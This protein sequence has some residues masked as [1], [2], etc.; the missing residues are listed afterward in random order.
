MKKVSEFSFSI[1]FVI[2]I[3]SIIILN[4]YIVVNMY[5]QKKLSENIFR[6]H[7]V[8]NSNSIDDQIIKLKI[9]EKVSNYIKNITNNCKNK[10]EL[11]NCIC[12]NIQ[13]ILNISNQELKNNNIT[14][15]TNIEIGN[16]KYAKKEDIEY[17]M[18]SGNY[19]SIK[20]NLGNANGK[21]IWSLLFPNQD[22]I[23][24]LNALESIL[25]G[26]SNIYDNNSSNSNSSNSDE[27]KKE[28]ENI[29]KDYTFKIVEI[30]NEAL[31]HD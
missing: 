25:P 13:N 31:N 7:V 22:N 11:K 4:L 1:P 17:T 5:N 23:K 18:P 30:V 24:N 26:I 3:I 29:K 9:N 16:I 14:Y 21:N 10:N 27:E 28:Y 19:D 15:K 6:L 12:S 2:A 8:A 20:I